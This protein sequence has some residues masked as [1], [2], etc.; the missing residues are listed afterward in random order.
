MELLEQIFNKAGI[1]KRLPIRVNFGGKDGDMGGPFVKLKRM[2]HYFPNHPKGYNLIYGVSGV[3]FP[4]DIC[5]KAKK[6]GVKIVC[7]LNSCWHPAYADDWKHKNR[8]LEGLHNL[9]ADYVVY[10]SK[11]AKAGAKRYIGDVDRVPSDIIYN[12]VDIGHYI[13]VSVKKDR[14]LTLLA[15]GFHQIR[16]RVEPLIRA[17]PLLKKNHP[18]LRL[19]IAGKLKDGKGIWDCG[20]ETI[21][22]LLQEVAFDQVEFVPSYTQEE[23]PGIYQRADVLVHLKHMDWTPNVVAE[24][25]ACGLPVVHTGNGG[26]PEIVQESGVS[27]QIP[28]NW[29]QVSEA[30]P[31]AVANAIEQA[32]AERHEL[33]SKAREIAESTFN[34]DS[35]AEKHRRIFSDL[36]GLSR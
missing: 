12:A 9:Y 20:E 1:R 16:H 3:D 24:A 5:K 21:R 14:P 4:L 19:I 31:Q 23:A 34:M 30:D 35:W 27:L 28:E 10:G 15:S 2:A 18:E 17:L 7:H 26:V 29:D 8:F 32:Y 36:L 11:Q 25:M 6:R 22:G 33:G 13:P